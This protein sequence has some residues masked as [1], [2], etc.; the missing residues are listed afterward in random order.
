MKKLAFTLIF[1]SITLWGFSQITI[2]NQN[3]AGVGATI[4]QAYDTLPDASIVPGDAGANQSWNFSA[5]TANSF[6]SLYTE[7]PG[8][9]PY[10]DSFPGSNYVIRQLYEMDTTYVF[11]NKNDDLFTT[12]GYIGSMDDME[13][14]AI[15][16]V[17]GFTTKNPILPRVC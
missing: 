7:N 9:T 13:V 3:I 14:M 10:P 16:L 6:D 11:C 1:A 4:V 17:P 2:T 8:W 12:L 15:H 5:L